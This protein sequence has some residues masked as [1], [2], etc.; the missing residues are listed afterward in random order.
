MKFKHKRINFS[1]E[2]FGIK[3]IVFKSELRIMDNKWKKR[4]I[5]NIVKSF[6]FIFSYLSL[7]RV[8]KFIEAF[9]RQKFAK[10]KVSEYRITKLKIK[11]ENTELT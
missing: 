8:I 11:I 1:K 9:K 7:P 2:A 4:M 6:Y 5:V 3:Y 10:G